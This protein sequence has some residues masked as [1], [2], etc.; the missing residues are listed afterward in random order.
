MA[1][2]SRVTQHE[3]FPTQW[4]VGHGNYELFLLYEHY[5][6]HTLGHALATYCGNNKVE[7]T[8]RQQK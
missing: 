3:L 4:T 8:W 6:V 2:A 1:A 5:I 7:T